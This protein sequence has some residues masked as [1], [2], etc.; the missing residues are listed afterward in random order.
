[1]IFVAAFLIGLFL[2]I[3]IIFA[4]PRF[5]PIPYF[6]SNPKDMPM[7]VE[8]LGLRNGQTVIDLGAGDGIVIFKSASKAYHEA[9]DTKFIA[10]EIN[11]VLLLILGIRKLLHPNGRNIRIVRADMFT[12]DY[13]KLL[14]PKSQSDVTLY[15][16]ISP[17]L[18]EKTIGNARKHMKKFNI[19]SYFYEVP[20]IRPAERKNGIHKLFRYRI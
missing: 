13:R 7:I 6:P 11:P 5:S 4:F 8:A 15:L 18:I 2:V 14:G 19:V 17:W 1:M 10:V 9:L 3:V 16:Y 20:G 12:L